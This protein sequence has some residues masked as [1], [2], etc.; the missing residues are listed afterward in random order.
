MRFNDTASGVL[1][2]LVGIGVVARALT[3]PPMPGQPIGPS[4]FPAVIGS[5]LVIVGAALIV[6]GLRTRTQAAV[7]FDQ[8]VS[9]PR[10]LLNFALVVG[11]LLFYALA[12]HRLG[13]FIT[14]VVFLTVLFLAF[15]VNRTWIPALVIVITILVHYGFYTLLRVPL[16]WGVLEAFAW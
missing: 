8:W 6:G 13:F 12:L 7:H 15:G 5:G 14:A 3:F 9:S 10:M 1:A 4:L 2:M 16:P 11:D